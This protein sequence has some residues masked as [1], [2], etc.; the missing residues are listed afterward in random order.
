MV[1]AYIWTRLSVLLALPSLLVAQAAGAAAA[2]SQGSTAAAAGPCAGF[3]QGVA[4]GDPRPDSVVL[5]TRFTPQ[6][7]S[8]DQQVQWH[9]STAANFTP[10]EAQVQGTASASPGA[11]FTVKVDVGSLQPATRYFYYFTSGNYSSLLGT[12]RTAPAE[13]AVA[14]LRFAQMSCASWRWGYFNVYNMTSRVRDLDF[15]VFL[16]DWIYEYGNDEYPA[17]GKGVSGRAPLEPPTEL[18]TLAD[19]RTR[20]RLFHTD[21]ALVEMMRRA[22]I[23]AVWDDHDVAADNAWQNGSANPVDS[24]AYANRR[25]NGVQ[26]YHEYMPIRGPNSTAAAGNNSSSSGNSSEVCGGLADIYRTF[27]FGSTMTLVMLEE[28]VTARAEQ[29]NYSTDPYMQTL[30]EHAPEEWEGLPDLTQKRQ[31]YYQAL[32]AE[33]RT[34]IGPK[35]ISQ[36]RSDFASSAKANVTWQVLGNTVVM[37]PLNTPD[38]ESAVQDQGF[39]AQSLLDGILSVATSDLLEVVPASFGDS[40]RV[41]VGTGR[42]HD[43]VIVDGWSGYQYERSQVLDI[44]SSSATNPVVLSGDIHNAFVWRLTPDN[45]TEPVAVEFT[46]A[47]VTAPGVDLLAQKLPGDANQLLQVA[48]RG[49]HISNNASMHYSNIR[50][51]GAV[52]HTV[53]PSS[54]HADFSFVATAQQPISSFQC[55]AAFQLSPGAAGTV[56]NAS[57]T[58][59]N[60]LFYDLY[61]AG[62]PLNGTVSITSPALQ[63]TNLTSCPTVLQQNQRGTTGSEQESGSGSGSDGILGTG[64]NLPTSRSSRTAVPVWVA[65]MCAAAAGALQ[66]V[67]CM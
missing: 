26:A 64:I 8:T 39:L 55:Q 4:S 59:R 30:K 20:H 44:L 54:W 17:A 53:S 29:Y 34:L 23:I 43:P 56:A 41:L 45:A 46:T 16:G 28:R 42:Y 62:D 38:V 18:A 40:A 50:D 37:G 1:S 22:P 67:L 63:G 52:Y 14:T 21:P 36:L 15:I 48:E 33:N 13:N 19:Y 65:L 49:L 57:C 24:V 58:P 35:Q 61:G 10:S 12:T 31:A 11:D 51:R 2:G 27:R 32:E 9:M 47:S 6:D 5:W 3:L 66:L 60:E 7:N 25:C